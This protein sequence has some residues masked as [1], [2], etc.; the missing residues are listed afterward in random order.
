M[1]KE[2]RELY[3]E[4][5][6]SHGGREPCVGDPRGRSEALDRV[7]VGWAIEQRNQVVR[8]AD[9]VSWGGRQHRRSRRLNREWPA[10]PA[11]SKNLCTDRISMRETR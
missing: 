6:A 1:E 2:M 9:A 4:D 11:L 5:L 3:I 10:E 7:G 8:G